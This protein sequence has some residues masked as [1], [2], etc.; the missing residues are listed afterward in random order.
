MAYEFKSPLFEKEEYLK[1]KRDLINSKLNHGKVQL[2][3]NARLSQIEI[4]IYKDALHTIEMEI[5]DVR[6]EM[7]KQGLVDYS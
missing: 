4:D 6:H 7:Y 2:G 5:F 3:G 1:T